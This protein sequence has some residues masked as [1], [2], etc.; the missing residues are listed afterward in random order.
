[1]TPHRPSAAITNLITR[2]SHTPADVDVGMEVSEKFDSSPSKKYLVCLLGTRDSKGSISVHDCA[3]FSVASGQN[4]NISD[5]LSASK[6]HWRDKMA[7]VSEYAALYVRIPELFCFVPLTWLMRSP[8][9][10]NFPSRKLKAL[11]NKGGS[12]TRG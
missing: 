3:E 6:K 8:S 9:P 10:S 12:L 2:S 5:L 11:K 7:D 4:A 1:M